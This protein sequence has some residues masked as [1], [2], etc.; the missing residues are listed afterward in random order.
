M[1]ELGYFGPV[2]GRPMGQPNL[3]FEEGLEDNADL[4]V[5][6]DETREE[7]VGNYR[8]ACEKSDATIQALELDTAGSVPW[9]EINPSPFI[10]SSFTSSQRRSATPGT[11]IS[12]ERSSM[13]RSATPPKTATSLNMTVSGGAPTTIGLSMKLV[14]LELT[15]NF[16]VGWW[17]LDESK[18]ANLLT[19]ADVTVR[20]SVVSD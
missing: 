17:S 8:K 11:L 15:R 5:R 3:W 19:D 13:V 14:S 2:F 12:H 6:A 1:V 20:P 4:F 7:I 10:T 9:W 18:R 16:V